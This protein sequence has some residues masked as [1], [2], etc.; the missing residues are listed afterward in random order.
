[1][2]CK[3]NEC[4]RFGLLVIF[5]ICLICAVAVS[6]AAA[7]ATTEVTITKL[8]DDD[9][10]VIDK[11]TISWEWM[12][13]NLPVLGDGQTMYYT[14]GPIFDGAWDDVHPDEEYDKW[15]PT[16]DVN[17]Y[18]KDHG[19]FMGTDVKDLCDLV[20]G[21][22]D[23]DSIT[24]KAIDGMHKTWPASYIYDPNPRQGP[25]GISWYHGEEDDGHGY[26]YV[27]GSYFTQGMR[28]YFFV[29][30]TNKDDM[31]VWG[32]WDM[33]ECWDEEY[34]HYYQNPE[35][36]SAS[37][38]SVQVVNRIIIH[39]NEPVPD[40][41]S[42]TLNGSTEQILTRA[43]FIDLAG[44][45]P[46]SYDTGKNGIIEGADL[47]A[48]IGLVDDE[49][50]TSLNDSLAAMNYTIEVYGKKKGSDHVSTVYSEEL[51]GSDKSCL[52][53]NRLDGIELNATGID[54]RVFFPL[55]LQGEVVDGT[56]RAVEEVSEVRLNLPSDPELTTIEITP[57]EGEVIAGSSLQFTASGYDFSGEP[58]TGRAFTWTSS[59][60][61][62]GDVDNTG[63]F[64]AEVPG[65]TTLIASN[66]LVSGSA[67]IT[68]IPGVPAD[69]T[70]TLR[71]GWNFISTP[72]ELAEDA[73][74][75]ALF[76]EVDCAGHSVWSY[77]PA[78][79]W[80][81]V[82]AEDTFRPLDG[83][84]VYSNGTAYLPLSLD[85]TVRETPAVKRLSA[86][87]N[88]VGFSD[89]SA[90][91]TKDALASVKDKWAILIG[92]DAETQSYP[93]SVISGAGGSHADTR[94]MEPGE[95]YWL[96]MRTDGT[97]G[98]ISA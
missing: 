49:D 81:A 94:E 3:E 92:F 51:I 59:N 1:M 41:W 61:T 10:T 39:S 62:V 91:P 8:A 74:T 77:S 35:Y 40:D 4:L 19:K 80:K 97:L 54:G 23:G 55:Y 27:N 6:P 89:I 28:L 33:H 67:E 93:T 48:V 66:G 64:M 17:L 24:V 30:T 26:G 75:F 29:E 50:P 36:P 44:E 2:N 69:F 52:L 90:A 13:D 53:G 21:A 98:A 65:I 63:L 70:L 42:V 87:W 68:V 71:D 20:G 57:A 72:A 47:R 32:N 34:W 31:L 25:M 12:K 86:G 82:A 5:C 11:K 96:F 9:T 43:E 7:E 45:H 83:I 60:L 84:W 15:N 78:K 73:N 18:Y 38:N 79:G 14:Q 58:M 76:S 46:A 95:G 37:G 22:G 56:G 16:E 85:D 88:A